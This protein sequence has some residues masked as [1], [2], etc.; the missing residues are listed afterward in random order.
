[1]TETTFGPVLTL[2]RDQV[3]AFLTRVKV[4]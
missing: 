3:A 4:K 1:M 2:T